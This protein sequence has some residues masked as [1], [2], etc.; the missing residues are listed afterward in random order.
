[1][2]RRIKSKK[3]IERIRRRNNIILGLVM[4][5]LLVASSAGYSIMS[6][7][8]DSEDVVNEHG[9][10]FVRD[11]GLWKMV[12]GEEVFAFQYLPSEVE[13]V[14]VNL[15]VQ[16]AQYSGQPVYFVKP[17]EGMTEILNNLGRYVM[18][19]QEAC[20]NETGFECKG[21]LPLKDC[22]SNLIIFEAGNETRVY[23]RDNCVFISGDTIRGTD[24][25]LHKLILGV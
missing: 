24:A 23:S 10:N 13:D 16:L 11:Q 14:D 17:N 15:S 2:M 8:N 5:F 22:S 18:R 7:E 1:M 6:A 9:F 21:N 3:D 12:V 20:I 25:Y 19:Y 4:I